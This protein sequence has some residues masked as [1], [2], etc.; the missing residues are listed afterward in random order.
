MGTK[1]GPFWGQ[2]RSFLG[3]GR[4]FLGPRKVLFGPR[5]ILL[6]PRKVLFLDPCL[7]FLFGLPFW[8]SCLGLLPLAEASTAVGRGIYCSW[9]RHLLQLAEA[10]T[11]VGRGI[12]CT[13]PK[14]CPHGPMGLWAPM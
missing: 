12:Y 9:P 11:A 13:G 1:E 7:D 6:G 14:E 10:S 8:T 2:G 3:Q 5:K 4:S